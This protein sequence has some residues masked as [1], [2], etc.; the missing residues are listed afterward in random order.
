MVEQQIQRG[1]IDD[2]AAL[3]A[4]ALVLLVG[5]HPERTVFAVVITGIEPV[6]EQGL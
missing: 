5:G 6:I 1:L 2:R 4:G 3:I